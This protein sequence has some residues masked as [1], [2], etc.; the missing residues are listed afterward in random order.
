MLK[1]PA[2][3]E[4]ATSPAKLTYIPRP[5]SSSLLGVCAGIC[6]TTLVDESEMIRTQM[7]MHNRS[8]NCQSTW[9]TVYD[10]TP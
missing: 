3:Y 6:H 1:I 9:D 8:E 7:G 4:R 10:T 5:V 2:E